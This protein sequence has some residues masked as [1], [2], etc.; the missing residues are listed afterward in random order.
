MISWAISSTTI[1]KRSSFGLVLAIFLTRVDELT[2]TFRWACTSR[3]SL[4]TNVTSVR[5]CELRN[6]NISDNTF[7]WWLLDRTFCIGGSSMMMAMCWRQFF[8]FNSE[9]IKS[10][11]NCCGRKSRF[12]RR[13]KNE[14]GR[15]RAKAASS[16]AA[17][18]A[19]SQYFPKPKSLGKSKM[20]YLHCEVL[21]SET[22]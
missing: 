19:A 6:L 18:Q 4:Q 7:L 21:C 15:Q 13:W 1:T 17:K 11:L 9:G 12:Q 16:W 8:C 5:H 10:F 14:P 22:L 20:V 3:D 2:K